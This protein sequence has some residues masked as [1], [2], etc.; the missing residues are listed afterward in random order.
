VRE[1]TELASRQ[2][3]RVSRRQLLEHGLNRRT[4][5]R[6][7]AAGRLEIVEEGVLAFTP[8]LDD[9][10]G[11][12]M[13]ATLTAP[14][15]YLSTISAA[16][17]RGVW[18]LPRPF[19][20]VTRVGSG[21]PR[22]LGGLRVYRS[23]TI[24]DEIDPD[25][26]DGIPI[27]TVE[28][29][30]LDLARTLYSDR[31]VARAVRESV[32]LELTT[33]PLVADYLGPRRHRRGTRRLGAAV[34]RYSGLPID[35]ARSGAEAVAMELLQGA[36]RT[37]PRLNYDVAGAEADLSWPKH[38]VIIEIDGRPFHMDLG[39]DTRKEGIWRGAGW[40]VRRISSDDVYEH[41]ARL[42][43]LAPP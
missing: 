6:W 42:L 34:A 2:F 11:R 27:T 32:R 29:M 7:V 25:P 37:L 38:R 19:E 16:A 18:S 22:R 30:L 31:A 1:I 13:G 33:I 21:G 15:T 5:D 17:S 41:P 9:E 40:E 14:D 8:V 28:R 24:L 12:W 26:P 3:N 4:I 43:A 20:T 10:R 23:T 39:E 35:R 36:A